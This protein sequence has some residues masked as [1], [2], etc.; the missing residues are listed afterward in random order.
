MLWSW[1][2]TKLRGP[3]DVS[4]TSSAAALS[5]GPHRG[6]ATTAEGRGPLTRPS[7]GYQTASRTAHCR[8][9]DNRLRSSAL[10]TSTTA[11]RACARPLKPTRGPYC[12]LRLCLIPSIDERHDFKASQPTWDGR[13]RPKDLTR[14][15][16]S[17]PDSWA[18]NVTH[19]ATRRERALLVDVDL[20]QRIVRQRR[21][22]ELTG[23]E[24]RDRG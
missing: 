7:S 1:D 2:I 18:K 20:R 4:S 24:G 17:T 12:A 19:L 11:G 15:G 22:F 23:A 9:S 14:D 6:A 3:K 10:P 8:C 13:Y 5:G 16:V 21:R